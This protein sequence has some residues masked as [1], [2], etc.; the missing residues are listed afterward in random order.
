MGLVILGIIL[1]FVHLIYYLFTKA[2]IFVAFQLFHVNW[3]GKFWV[4]YLFVF[5]VGWL[6]KSNSNRGN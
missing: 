1:G 3:Y 6:V 2:T 5:L 4:V